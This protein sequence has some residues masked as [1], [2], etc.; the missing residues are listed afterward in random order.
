MKKVKDKKAPLEER[1][2]K[3][4]S[5][6]RRSRRADGKRLKVRFK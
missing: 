6:V 4:V 5:V 2:V 3:Q 1:S